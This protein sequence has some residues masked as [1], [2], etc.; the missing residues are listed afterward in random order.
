[1]SNNDKFIKY[2]LSLFD[3]KKTIFHIEILD[4]V[5]KVFPRQSRNVLNARLFGMCLDNILAYNQK[6]DLYAKKESE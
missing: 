3:K 4:K 5:Q 2:V 1:M 6:I